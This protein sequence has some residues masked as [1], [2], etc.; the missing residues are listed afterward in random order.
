[1]D[2][3]GRSIVEDLSGSLR[4]D[5]RCDPLTVAMYASD[6]SLY[7]IAP[8]GVAFPRDRDDVVLLARYSA[9][10]DVPLSPR[11]AGSG[12]AGSC[13]GSGLVVD[14][15]RY[16]RRIEEIGDGT[17]R[18]QPGIVRDRLNHVLRQHGRYFPPDPA[19][20]GVTTVGSML[21][22]DAAGSHAI[23]VG[24][25]RDHVER[26]EVVLSG[27]SVIEAGNE[28]LDILKTPPAAVPAA[29]NLLEDGLSAA[30][31]V[32]PNVKRTIIS[33]LSK[34]LADHEELIQ[35]RQPAL[36]RNC[37]GYYVRNVLSRTHLHLPRLLVGSEGTLGLFTSAVLN[38]APLPA[39]RGVVLLLFGQL[40]AAIRSVQIIAR[41]QPSACDLLDRRLLS[42]ARESHERFEA[43][44][45]PAAEAALLVEQTGFS[46]R[47]VRDRIRMAVQAV[48]AADSEAVVA[49][50]AYTFDDVEFLWTLPGKVVPLLTRL[51]GPTRPLPFVEDVAV[52][53]ETLH[54][55][56]L[57][58]QRVF[59]R[60]QVTASLYAHAASGQVHLRPFLPPPTPDDGSRIEAIARDL[61]QVAFS[62]GGAISGEHGDGLAR[63]AFI[64]S[65]YGELYKV[66]QQI[67]DLFD[68]HNLLNPGKIISDDPHVTI[69]NLRP[70]PTAVPETIELQLRWKPEELSQA[71]ARCNGC[72][73]CKTQSDE[74]RMCPF[75]RLDHLEEASPRSK[76][77]VVRNFTSGLLDGNEFAS[78]DMKR[79][80]SLCFNCKQCQLECPSNVNIPQMMIEAKAAYVQAHGLSR[81]DWILSR[82]HSFGAAG[83]GAA[84]F[85]N[86][87]VGNPTARW[88]L[89]AFV[90]IARQRK[91]PQFARRS[92]IRSAG[93]DLKRLPKLSGK[94]ERPV[95]YFVSEYANYHDTELARA[96]IAV[97]QHN[98]VPVHVPPGQTSSGMAMISAGDLDAAREVAEQNVRIL[99][100]LAR[101]GH[102]IVC[103]EPAAALCLKQEYPQLLDH[104]DVGVLASQVVEAGAFLEQLHR[105]GRLRTDFQPLDLTVGYHTPCHIKA[106][107]HGS[108][109][110][111]LLSLIPELKV[112]KIEKGCSGMAGAFGLTKQ[113]FRTSVRIGWGLIS[114]MRQGDLD[115]G[116]TECTSCK[117]QMEQGTRIPT[118]HPLKL[119]AL[120]YGLMPEIR[121]RLAPNKRKLIVS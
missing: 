49:C 20:S 50:E 109:L 111:R 53:P 97:L 76:A 106:L 105:A 68:P 24:S 39:H 37:S 41:Q 63:T 115:A 116:T 82:A 26:I 33:K 32:D 66:F 108:A 35:T 87:V 60:H 48:H 80:A 79:L 4:G 70:S 86:W 121:Q 5:L 15:S 112:L 30:S 25:T 29:P 31:S 14:F 36:V 67:K 3:R 114:R 56:L 113:N 11:G 118:V 91:L 74:F 55:F 120:S 110:E 6:A 21:A 57:R 89:E 65:Q 10:M 85:A 119:M 22:I 72:G 104:P 94:T 28:P 73:A 46:D 102:T 1:M 99:G 83:S 98:G 13:L 117:M 9:E 23:R 77:N 45:S 95:V 38:T 78:A 71:A 12:L 100:E 18:V 27:G 52:P 61:Y 90:G 69:R 42:L 7:Q 8:V 43:L 75:F 19:N 103:T 16:M 54:E 92:F 93:R 96:F 84:M 58:A 2:E 44:I 101:E 62:F 81:A 59:Q 17:V 47:Q 51:R 107:G 34:L 64:R 88:L 40:E